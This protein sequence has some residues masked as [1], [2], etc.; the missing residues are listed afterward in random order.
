MDLAQT[1]PVHLHVG[2]FSHFVAVRTTCFGSRNVRVS[3]FW[4]FG[5]NY[6]SAEGKE[7]RRR[8][9]CAKTARPAPNSPRISR[10]RPQNRVDYTCAA[11]RHGQVSPS[12]HLS[13]VG[14]G[15]KS[16]PRRTLTRVKKST[17]PAAT[18]LARGK[19]SSRTQAGDINWANYA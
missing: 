16:W 14:S 3:F 4:V 19:V 10:P 11:A 7:H 1:W 2:Y 9:G 17:G 12:T 8:D 18:A 13:T 15:R 6:V 5:W